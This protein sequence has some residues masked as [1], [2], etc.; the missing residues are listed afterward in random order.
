MKKKKNNSTKQNK[1]KPVNSSVS[2][3]LFDDCAICQ[4]EKDAIKRGKSLSTS[5]L[6][7]VFKRAKGINS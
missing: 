2:K 3:Y 1:I 6:K 4:A 5:E 7:D